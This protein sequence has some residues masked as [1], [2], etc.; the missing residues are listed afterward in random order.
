MARGDIGADQVADFLERGLLDLL[1][2][3]Y[4]SDP[5]LYGLLGELLGDGRISVRL[6]AAALVEELAQVD[7]PGRPFAAAA[8]APLL[9]DPDPVRRGDAAYLLGFA[10]AAAERPRLE[11]LAADDPNADVREAAAEAVDRIAARG[12]IP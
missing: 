6:G 1:V 7:P 12:R 10:G 4:R 8:I 9:D 5:G 11:A 3:L 2:P